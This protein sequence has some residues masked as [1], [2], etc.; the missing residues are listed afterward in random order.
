MKF[1]PG[2]IEEVGQTSL[3]AS[4]GSVGGPLPVSGSQ[5]GMIVPC[6]DIFSCHSQK[7]VAVGT[8]QCIGQA[9]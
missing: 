6:R 2:H 7:V 1:N 9:E 4:A 5:P 8:L 3:G